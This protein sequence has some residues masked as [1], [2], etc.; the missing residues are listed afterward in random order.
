MP[1]IILC[2]LTFEN[3]DY[4]KAAI[5]V[6]IF[7]IRSIM[8]HKHYI[9]ELVAILELQLK[10]CQ[11]KITSVHGMRISTLMMMT[12]MDDAHYVVDETLRRVCIRI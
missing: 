9:S 12:I 2:S 5:L 6:E 4:E 8:L 1:I 3:D 10:L 7:G 11:T